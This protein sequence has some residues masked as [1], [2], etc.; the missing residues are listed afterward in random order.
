[1]KKALGKLPYSQKITIKRTW[2]KET[3][4]LKIIDEIEK[5]PIVS[6]NRNKISKLDAVLHGI[7]KHFVNH[8]KGFGTKFHS[9]YEESPDVYSDFSIAEDSHNV[10]LN[11][12]I[13]IQKDNNYKTLLD[14]A[15]GTGKLL[16]KIHDTNLF[17]RLYG[18]DLSSSLLKFAKNK[19]PKE[20]ILLLSR[21]ESIPLLENEIDLCIT[22]WGSF[23]PNETLKEMERVTRN[24]GMIVRVGTN[25]LDDFTS[26]FPNYE[27]EVVKENL[28]FIKLCGFTT[29]I[30]S[31]EIKFDSLKKARAVISKITGCIPSKVTTNILN[32]KISLSWKIIK[33]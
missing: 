2:E 27:E 32:H 14:V 30:L 12:I 31:I 8:K 25:C 20:I 13:N 17:S 22:T 9:V 26:L 19:L 15:C 7:D 29:E 18:L 10:I 4:Y 24:G 23:S 33:K 16:N 28:K 5:S 3:P 11:K 21:A 6:K 1:M